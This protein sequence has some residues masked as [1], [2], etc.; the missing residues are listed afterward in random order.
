MVVVAGEVVERELVRGTAGCPVCH[1]EVRI[2]AG[3]VWFGAPTDGASAAPTSAATE[4]NAAALE[5]MIALLG[6]AEPEGTVLL[7]GAYAAFALSI[8]KQ[9]GCGVVTVGAPAGPGATAGRAADLAVAAVR[10]SPGTVP[11]ADATFRAAALDAST[12]AAFAADVVRSVII[13]GRVLGAAALARPAG[14]RELARDTAE[15]VAER[16][17]RAPIVALGRRQS[18]T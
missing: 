2:D 6:L 7:A 17:A 1:A 4:P 10:G 9:T 13:G 8:A 11:F 16:E 18:P 3:D 12:N 15:W 5:R 14:V